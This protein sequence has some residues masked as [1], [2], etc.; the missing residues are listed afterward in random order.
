ME[1]NAFQTS[2]KQSTN[3]T[4]ALCKD[5][6]KAEGVFSQDAEFKAQAKET[7]GRLSFQFLKYKRGIQTEPWIFSF[8]SKRENNF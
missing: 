5:L 6:F 2:L 1:S 4:I 8:L 7:L 3:Q